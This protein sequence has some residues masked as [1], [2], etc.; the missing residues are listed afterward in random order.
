MTMTFPFTMLQVIVYYNICIYVCMY[1]HTK[2]ITILLH[3]SSI[4]CCNFSFP[5][6]LFS[7]VFF[8][9]FSMDVGLANVQNGS[10]YTRCFGGSICLQ[11]YSGIIGQVSVIYS[12]INIKKLL[13][14]FFLFLVMFILFIKFIFLLQKGV[15]VLRIRI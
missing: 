15:F 12:I 9:L 3:F 10:L 14:F 8:L 7:F 1:L 13:Y 4:Q 2:T 11:S 6:S 5:F